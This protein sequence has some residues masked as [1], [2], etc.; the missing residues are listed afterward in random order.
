MNQ[1]NPMN[2]GNANEAGDKVEGERAPQEHDRL[3]QGIDL[4]ELPLNQSQLLDNIQP[5]QPLDRGQG[6]A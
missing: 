5:E 3:G 4:N 6:P 2:E 1:N